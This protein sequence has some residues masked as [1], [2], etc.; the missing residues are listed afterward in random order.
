MKVIPALL[1]FV[2]FNQLGYSQNPGHSETGVH[3]FVASEVLQTSNYTYILAKENDQTQWLAIPKKEVSIGETYYYQGGNKMAN[4]KSTE[5]DRTF[6]SI[7][8]LGGV[9]SE[10]DLNNSKNAEIPTSSTSGNSGNIEEPIDPAEGGITIEELFAQRAD[11]AGK[12][13]KI[14]GMVTK[15]NANIMG[16]NWLHIQDGTD[17][18]GENDLVVTSSSIVKKGDIVTLEG[19]ISVDKDFGYGYFYKV[20]MEN[21]KVLK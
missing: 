1:A 4:F 6:D 14:R 3:E 16:T 7:L 11:Y 21:S 20:I 10:E 9:I 15:F 19:K 12:T 2:I 17:H 18:Q 5:L 13:V 8:F